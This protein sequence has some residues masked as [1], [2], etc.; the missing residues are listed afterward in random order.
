MS[1]LHIF[2]MYNAEREFCKKQDKTYRL[3]AV[4]EGGIAW[5]SN[6]IMF[7]TLILHVIYVKITPGI[8]L[9]HFSHRMVYEYRHSHQT[10]WN[11]FVYENVLL[12]VCG[13]N[14]TSAFLLLQSNILMTNSCKN[15]TKN[16]TLDLK[17]RFIYLFITARRPDSGS[18]CMKRVISITMNHHC[19]YPT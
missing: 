6:P 4:F 1:Y 16:K 19:T 3:T 9:F 12:M 17:I 8:G 18:A 10:Y 5:E 15:Q 14:A 13:F 7:C 11:L 2:Y